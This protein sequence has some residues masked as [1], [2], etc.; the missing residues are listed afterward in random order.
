MTLSF[1][2]QSK[3]RD[4][5]EKRK[6]QKRKGEREMFPVLAQILGTKKNSKKKKKDTVVVARDH[7]Q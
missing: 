6:G 3:C 2:S 4:K 5:R 7:F 1:I